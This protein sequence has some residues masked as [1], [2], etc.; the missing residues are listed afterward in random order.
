[1]TTPRRVM[2]GLLGTAVTAYRNNARAGGPQH[3]IYVV[4]TTINYRLVLEAET[5]I[6]DFLAEQGKQRP[7]EPGNGFHGASSRGR[8]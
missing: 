2:V 1:M 4:P 8:R 7:A 5:L 3:R 6:D